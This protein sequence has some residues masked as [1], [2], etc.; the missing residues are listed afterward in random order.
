MM[1]QVLSTVLEGNAS[2]KF[3]VKGS[4]IVQIFRLSVV[5]TSYHA[6]LRFMHGSNPYRDSKIYWILPL[7]KSQLNWISFRKYVKKDVV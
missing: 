7:E 2:S 5:M 4:Y 3:Y 1:S 6:A